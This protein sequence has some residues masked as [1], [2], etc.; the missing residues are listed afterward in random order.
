MSI[1]YPPKLQYLLDQPEAAL[2]SIEYI[3]SIPPEVEDMLAKYTLPQN[4]EKYDIPSSFLINFWS[5]L[6]TILIIALLIVI[7]Y[8]IAYLTKNYKFLNVK[9]IKLKE[10]IKWNYLLGN[11]IGCYGPI[12]F[13]SSFEMRTV[14]FESVLDTISFLTCL[15]VNFAVIAIFPKII[16]ILRKIASEKDSNKH[17]EIKEKFKDY[18]IAFESYKNDSLLQQSCFLI[19]C[20]RL[21]FFY[22][23]LGCLFEYPLVQAILINLQGLAFLFYLLYIRPFKEK[24]DLFQSVALEFILQ[25]IHV[26]VLGLAII[27]VSEHIITETSIIFG[28]I[29]IICN[30]VFLVVGF[31]CLIID[32]VTNIITFIKAL[33][34][35][36]TGAAPLKKI[37][38]VQ[39]RQNAATS[40]PKNAISDLSI[41]NETHDLMIPRQFSN[42]PRLEENIDRFEIFRKKIL[43]PNTSSSLAQTMSFVSRDTTTFSPSEI[44]SLDMSMINATHGPLAQSRFASK[45]N[46]LNGLQ[47][48]MTNNPEILAISEISK[49]S[50]AHYNDKM[51][52][53][54]KR[55]LLSKRLPLLSQVVK[56]KKDI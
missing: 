46:T 13:Y 51:E 34:E 33:R 19:S 25:L 42:I 14:Q 1:L 9:L 20:F 40:S 47:S 22:L 30:G 28:E 3:S 55:I 4:F 54:R 45:T 6:T 53:L 15:L 32:L 2:Y 16:I 56:E 7:V 39:P 49:D 12:A 21:Y 36:F 52:I 10:A 43:S 17:E 41:M 48:D 37:S 23:V 8:L 26:S 29:I 50:K 18:Q 11:F 24:L 38:I 27:D 31:L 35:K 5:S 44:E